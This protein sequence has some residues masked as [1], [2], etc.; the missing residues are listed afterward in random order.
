MEV[1]TIA[2]IYFLGWVVEWTVVVSWVSAL[3]VGVSASLPVSG[4]K[5][6]SHE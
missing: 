3:F 5:G 2:E 6:G 4:M 1:G